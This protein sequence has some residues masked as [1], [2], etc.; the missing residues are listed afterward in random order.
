MF[1]YKKKKQIESIF[2]D[3]RFEIVNSIVALKKTI[4]VVIDDK[5][6]GLDDAVSMVRISESKADSLRA[7]LEVLLYGKAL[8]PESRGDIFRLLEATDKIANQGEVVALML[9]TH[10][11]VFPDFCIG[12]ILSMANYTVNIVKILSEAQEKVFSNYRMA[13]PLVGKISQIESDADDI[14]IC[15]TETIF[16][17]EIEPYNKLILTEWIRLLSGICDKAEDVSDLI[18]II[19]A[20]RGF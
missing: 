1:D 14:E 10:K 13:L 8:F 7:E 11:I 20:K 2:S 18:R 9:R 17:S 5:N 16:K 12:S 15:L 3:F 6:I 19:V 4:L